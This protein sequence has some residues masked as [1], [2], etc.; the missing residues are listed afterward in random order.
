MKMSKLVVILVAMVALVAAMPAAMGHTIDVKPGSCPNAVNLNQNGLL[1]IA[2]PG[3]EMFDVMTIDPATVEVGFLKW[4]ETIQ[5]NDRVYVPIVKYSYEDVIA[6]GGELEDGECCR[7]T[8][9]DGYTDLSIKVKVSDLVAAGLT[10]NL[11]H[12]ATMELVPVTPPQLE[13]RYKLLDLNGGE[14]ITSPWDQLK[15]IDND[16]DITQLQYDCGEGEYVW[17]GTCHADP[18]AAPAKAKGNNGKNK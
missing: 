9:P 14:F 7:I 8:E 17:K 4:N 5:D 12:T 15:L 6:T 10:T 2:I 11:T 1:P 13:V 16:A 18:D 3:T